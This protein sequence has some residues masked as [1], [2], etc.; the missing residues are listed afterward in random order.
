[1]ELPENTKKILQNTDNILR[2]LVASIIITATE[3]TIQWNCIS[4]VNSLS[5]AG[6]T[7][8]F[9]IGIAVVIRV[10]YVYLD[11]PH[12][13]CTPWPPWPPGP[14]GPPWPPGPPGL[15]GPST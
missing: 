11:W 15:P 6:Q 7:I 13:P 12:P 1:M 8:P 9:L 3:L 2:I 14:A 4:E 5:S 10:I